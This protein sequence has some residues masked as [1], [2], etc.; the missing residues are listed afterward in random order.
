VTGATG[1]TGATGATGETGVGVAGATGATGAT[2]ERGATGDTGA[3]GATGPA[4]G[5]LGTFF[6]KTCTL[7]YTCTCDSS[8]IL[9]GGG[10][11]CAAPNALGESGPDG[12]DP[13]HTW[14]AACVQGNNSLLPVRIII[15]CA[16]P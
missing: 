14:R 8:Y 11:A 10:A 3:T 5:A 16:M 13:T 2:G 15:V 6:S 4:G 1:L 7:A 9:I 12:A